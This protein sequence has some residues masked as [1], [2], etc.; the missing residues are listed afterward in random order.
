MTPAGQLHSVIELVETIL[1]NPKKPADAVMQSYFRNRRYIGSSDRRSIGDSVYGVLRNAQGIQE[2]LAITTPR[3]LVFAHCILDKKDTLGEIQY[4]CGEGYGPALLSLEEQQIL[5]DLKPYNPYAIPKWLEAHLN[6]QALIKSLHDQ[7]TVDIRVNS[8]KNHRDAILT[9]LKL[10]GFE[11]TA[12][13][14]SPIGIRFGKRQPL[15]NHELWENGTLEVQDEAS[16]IASLLCNAQPGMQVLDYCAGAGGKSLSL[17]ATMQNKGNLILSDIHPHRLQRAKER[18]RRAGVTTYQLKDIAK[19]NN[20]FKR[21]HNRFDR[22]LVDAPCTGTGTWRRNPDL[23]N[24]LTPIDLEELVT[25]QRKIL[26]Q[27]QQ[28]VKPGGRLVYVTCSVLQAE[29]D[30]QVAWLLNKYPQLKIIPIGKIWQET[31]G[32]ACPFSTDTAQFTPNIHNTDGFFVSIF[33]RIN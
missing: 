16:Q 12:T 23:K 7:A 3:L 4:L 31:I 19:D 29:N 8:L 26:D 14:I 20:W 11:V 10:E 32:D 33:E 25:L 28:F 27:A 6:D 22:V 1:S 18:L 15:S 30:Q 17:A 13:P 21:Q 9:L 24:R 2:A 5:S